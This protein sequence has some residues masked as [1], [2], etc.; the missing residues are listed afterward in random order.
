MAALSGDPL[1]SVPLYGVKSDSSTSKRRAS[2]AFVATHQK[3]SKS[4]TI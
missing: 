2:A 3:R 1:F 4:R